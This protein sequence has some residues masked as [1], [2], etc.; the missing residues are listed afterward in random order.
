[1][2]LSYGYEYMADSD[3][4]MT[5]HRIFNPP[6]PELNSEP[7]T[8][9]YA[10]THYSG[11]SG[12]GAKG[13]KRD[14]GPQGPKGNKRD[15]GPRGNT[16]SRGPKGNKGDQGQGTKGDKGDTGPQGS[17]GLQGLKGDKG[18]SNSSS[19]LSN[20][21]FTMQ[22]RQGNMNV[23]RH[24]I[25]NLPDPTRPTEPVCSGFPRACSIPSSL[26]IVSNTMAV[27]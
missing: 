1:M 8:K 22:R 26:Q 19:G 9:E 13:D 25:I 10:D 12:S 6:N 17:Q 3:I 7:V 20:T 15:T 23:V 2:S 27:K 24:K 18:D 16:G 4:N 14:I 21:G 11:G 5:E